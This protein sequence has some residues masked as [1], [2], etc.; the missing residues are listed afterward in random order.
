MTESKLDTAE[1]LQSIWSLGGLTWRELAKRV[2]AEI[3][4][5]DLIN[6]AYELAYNFLLAVFPLLLFLIALFGIFASFGGTLQSDLFAYAQH[7]LPPAAFNLV[8]KTIDQIIHNSGG[9]KLTFGLLFTLYSGSTG[10]TQL[11]AMLNVAYEVQ[12]RRSWIKVHL[13]SLGLTLIMMAFVL[14]A[15]LLVLA[16]GMAANFLGSHLGLSSAVIVAWKVV[17]VVLAIAFVTFGFAVIYYFAPD[18]H[19]RHWYWITPGSIIGVLLWLIT[20][21]ALRVYLHFFNTYSKTYGSLGAV[22]ILMLWFYVTGFAF[23]IGGEV[24]SVIEHAAAEHGHP[25]A[26]AEGQKKAA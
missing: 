3:T 20:S 22:M 5:D 7:V 16:G 17:Q 25:E 4:H 8:S 9:G 26:K 18:L 23:L 15:M 14:A 6:R 19:E 12:E 24:N 10:M 11:I 1:Q 13:I 21:E 2:Y